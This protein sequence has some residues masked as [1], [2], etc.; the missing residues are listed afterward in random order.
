MWRSPLLWAANRPPGMSVKPGITVRSTSP[1]GMAVA[2]LRQQDAD[3]NREHGPRS[4]VVAL[5]IV[6]L[7]SQYKNEFIFI[8]YYYN[9]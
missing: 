1:P 5:F 4:Y 2:A 3:G 8:Y 6:L 9:S 7:S